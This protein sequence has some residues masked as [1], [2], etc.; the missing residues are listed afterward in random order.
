MSMTEKEAFQLISLVSDS[1]NM[2]FHKS[3]YDVWTS[4][5]I[6]EGDYEASVKKLK[7]YIKESKYKPTLADVLATKPKAFEIKEKPVEETH[8]YKL[9]ND[10]EY[11]RKWQEVKRKGQAFIKELRSND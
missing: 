5:L 9:E 2:E 1:Y 4:I 6:K 8:Q 11:A 3:K 10:P 7:N